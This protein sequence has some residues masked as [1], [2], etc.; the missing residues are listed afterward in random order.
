MC[1]HS[2]C[3]V[4]ILQYILRFITPGSRRTLSSLRRVMHRAMGEIAPYFR[5][6]RRMLNENLPRRNR[7]FPV[8]FLFLSTPLHARGSPP[9]LVI[10]SSNQRTSN[11]LQQSR[12]NDKRTTNEMLAT[13]VLA[14]LLLRSVSALGDFPCS[15][16]PGSQPCS[17]WAVDPARQGEISPTAAC[18]P[19][20]F[21]ST[22]FIV[23]SSCGMLEGT[24]RRE[25]AAIV[26][27]S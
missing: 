25:D 6:V 14:L 4:W 10:R 9:P 13:S 17:A 23:S 3:T 12:K 22:S 7:K 1:A 8:A 16:A 19:G 27:R 18:T 11:R 24:A 15:G 21:I 26:R 5:Q 20:Q 2:V